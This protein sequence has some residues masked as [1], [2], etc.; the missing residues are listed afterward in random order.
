MWEVA[1]N[2]TNTGKIFMEISALY[3]VGERKD[4]YYFTIIVEEYEIISI[5]FFDLEDI[6]ER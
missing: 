1:I 5:D 6:T 2:I 3:D 4:M